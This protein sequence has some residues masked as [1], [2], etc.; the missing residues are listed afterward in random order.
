MN[1]DLYDTR[2]F[3]QH[4]ENIR[5]NVQQ[6]YTYITRIGIH[7]ENYKMIKYS[8]KKPPRKELFSSPFAAD[9]PSTHRSRSVEI[10]NYHF[11]Q[12][13]NYHFIRSC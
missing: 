9:S 11:I 3:I 12:I 6:F 7:D 1:N 2:S 5:F 4:W 13:S 8:N 10:S